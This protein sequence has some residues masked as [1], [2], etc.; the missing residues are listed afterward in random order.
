MDGG[1]VAAKTKAIG[2]AIYAPMEIPRL[3]R[4]S[5]PVPMGKAAI[6]GTLIEGGR[7]V[8][9]VLAPSLVVLRLVSQA[10]RPRLTSLVA[11]GNTTSV[12]AVV[13]SAFCTLPAN[14]GGGPLYVAKNVARLPA[15]RPTSA[16]VA[17]IATFAALPSARQRPV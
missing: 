11:D 10:R 17:A 9:P 2:I 14:D 15:S 7:A 3:G 5:G 12:D 1:P 13:S 6:A 16:Q 8:R 4:P